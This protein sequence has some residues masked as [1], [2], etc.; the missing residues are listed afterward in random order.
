M[1]KLWEL[2][3]LDE[4]ELDFGFYRIMHAKAQDVKDFIEADLLVY[5]SEVIGE[6]QEAD[7]ELLEK[8]LAEIRQTA[9]EFGA[10]KP[11]ET[12]PVKEAKAKLEAAKGRAVTEADVFDHLFRFFERYYEGGDFL[13]RRYYTRETPGRA[14]PYAI[15]YNGE[16]VKLHWANADQFYVKSS[17][18]FSTFTFDLM[19]APDLK[20]GPGG[21]SDLN[22]QHETMRVHFRVIHATEG[23]H[24]N[25]NSSDDQKRYYVLYRDKPIEFTEQDELLVNFVYKT[26]K[27]EKGTRDRIRTNLN[28]ESVRTIL[29]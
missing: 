2:F 14:S 25:I 10:S 21:L 1:K 15:P 23:E 20:S 27:V 26:L 16:E 3:R 13:S 9:K 5:I 7:K 18:Q 6:F 28:L 22:G 19:Q 29:D 4:P 24:G 17:E 11:E 12:K 8:N